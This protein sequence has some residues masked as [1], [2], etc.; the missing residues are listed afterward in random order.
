[1]HADELV[2]VPVLMYHQLLARPAGD[3]DQTPAQF[4]GQL[5]QLYAHHFQTITA[6]ALAAGLVDLPA[7]TS[8]MVLTFDDSTV[9]E[10]RRAAGRDSRAGLCGG[11]LAV[12][13]PDVRPGPPGRKLLCHARLCAGKDVYLR[14]LDA[15]GVQ[16]ELTQGLAVIIK[17][18]PGAG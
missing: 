1:M 11:H 6:A 12:G 5:Q 9:S 15:A 16:R 10:V 13:R 17:V 3:Y 2:A 8:P 18:V 4:R 14:R 7:G